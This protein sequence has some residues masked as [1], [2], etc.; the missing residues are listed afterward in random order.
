MRHG[1]QGEPR[2]GTPWPA[3]GAP[4]W[5]WAPPGPP[6]TPLP[7]ACATSG[8][9]A[10]CRHRARPETMG[11]ARA[12]RT[13]EPATSLPPWRSW[14]P[15]L[16]SWPR[17]FSY[18]RAPA[19]A[20]RREGARPTSRQGRLASFR[21]TCVGRRHGVRGLTRPPGIT[22]RARDWL[23]A[24]ELWGWHERAPWTWACPGSPPAPLPGTQAA[25]GRGLDGQAQA[26]AHTAPCRPVPHRPR[27]NAS[28]SA[29]PPHRHGSSCRAHGGKPGEIEA[30]QAIRARVPTATLQARQPRNRP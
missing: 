11:R 17:P 22:W 25:P 6:P 12:S 30:V 9:G 21:R 5:P 4:S 3:P 28:F 15:P 27:P 29:G 8:S 23:G 10:L 18:W 13:W 14:S 1:P 26:R 20:Q 16:E 7:S 2:T 24:H 19:S